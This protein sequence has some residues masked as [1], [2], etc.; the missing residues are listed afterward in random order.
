[1]IKQHLTQHV[2]DLYHTIEHYKEYP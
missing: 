2:E 1:V